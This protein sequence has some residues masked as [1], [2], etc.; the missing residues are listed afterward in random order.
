MIAWVLSIFAMIYLDFNATTPICPEAKAAITE[1]M[2]LYGNPSSGHAL[3]KAA[4][5]KYEEARG[6]IASLVNAD[7][8]E[9]VLMSCGTETINYCLRGAALAAKAAGHGNHIITSSVEHDA[10]LEVVRHLV[11]EHGFEAT[12]LGVDPHGRVSAESVA[13]AVTPRTVLVSIMHSNNEVGTVNPIAEIARGLKAARASGAAQGQ[14]QGGGALAVGVAQKPAILFHSDTS[15]SLGKLAVD[16][17][18]LGVDFLTV[19][20]H[21]LYAPKGVGALYIRRGTPPLAKLM[22]GAGH[23]RGL[24]AGTESTLLVAGLGAACAVARQGMAGATAHLLAMRQRLQ[25]N[26]EARFPP[27]PP[28]PPA[29]LEGGGAGGD[30]PPRS[31]ASSGPPIPGGVDGV[32]G[33]GSGQVQRKCGA[34]RVNGHPEERLPNTLSVSFRGILAPQLMARIQGQIA[35]SAGAACHSHDDARVSHVLAAMGVP[36][37]YARGTLRLSVG[38]STTAEEVDEAAKLIADAVEA[39]LAEAN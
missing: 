35:C 24:R 15:Q 30:S 10:V 23:E 31:E 39:L 36:L 27:P 9:V 33:G 28:P 20:G 8:D 3:G 19:T 11:R 4:K 14:G 22:L 34:M 16:A 6:R 12:F 38:K 5:E 25:A 17:R 18:A 1:S 29:S 21:K 13:R 37:D 2:E 32:G 7:P 26:L